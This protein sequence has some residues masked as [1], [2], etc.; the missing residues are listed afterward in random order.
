MSIDVEKIL[1]F[2]TGTIK[3][4]INITEKRTRKFFSNLGL[5]AAIQKKNGSMHI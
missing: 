3:P 4:A 2:K 5:V 1:V